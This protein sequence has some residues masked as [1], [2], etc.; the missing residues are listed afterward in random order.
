[1]EEDKLEELQA[2]LVEKEKTHF[3]YMVF[4]Q[5]LVLHVF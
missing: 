1:M 2:E 3:L 5:P 4:W